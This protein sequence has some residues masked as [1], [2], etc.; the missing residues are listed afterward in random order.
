MKTN[1]L[2]LIIVML[3]AACSGKNDRSDA[4][5]NFEV[6]DVMISAE[7][8]GKLLTF[9]AI[10]GKSLSSGELVAVI[11]TIDLVLKRSQFDAQKT[12]ISARMDNIRAQIEV[13]KQQKQNLLTDKA[14]IEKLFKDGAAT[15]K[16]LDD[17]NKMLKDASI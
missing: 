2:F 9:T 12:S 7:A 6:D 14:R 4:Y 10:E 11:D 13:Q 15:Q 8:S 17:V 16:Q 3:L 5:G 1:N